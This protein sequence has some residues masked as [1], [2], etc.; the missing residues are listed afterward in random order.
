MVFFAVV[1][2]VAAFFTGIFFPPP[3]CI[4][5][6]FTFLSSQKKWLVA[7]SKKFRLPVINCRFYAYFTFFSFRKCYNS[8]MDIETVSVD[9]SQPS[10]QEPPPVHR[11][12][13][14]PAP[15]DTLAS[16]QTVTDPNLGQTVNILD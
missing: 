11:E 8:Y 7:D 15:A 1:F 2:F 13:E 6:I 14:Q 4:M 16:V 5:S 10:V 9:M 12:E 3:V